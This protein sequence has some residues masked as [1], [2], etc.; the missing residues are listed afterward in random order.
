ME[1]LLMGLRLREGISTSRYEKLT[2]RKLDQQTIS[3]LADQQ[4]ITLDENSDR[5]MATPKGRR[6]LNSVTS[7]LAMSG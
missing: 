7:A 6:L 2:G 4:L 1:M 5:L 3:L